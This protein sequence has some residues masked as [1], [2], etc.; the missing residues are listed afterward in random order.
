MNDTVFSYWEGPKSPLIEICQQSL[1]RWNR[2]VRI[3]GPDD[4][5]AEILEATAGISLAYR[6]DL[7]R[8]WA[9]LQ[10]GGIWVDADTV[11]VGTLTEL[12][13]IPQWD[14][15]G[16]Y[17]P[18]QQRGWAADGVLA[19]PIGGRQG[20]PVL[21]EMF[22]E[23]LRSVGRIQAGKKVPYGWTSV[24]LASEA[25][26]RHR[27][28]KRT[29]RKQHWQLHPVPWYRAR[30]IFFR[31]APA[32]RHEQSSHWN[33]NA[34]LYH[35]TNVVTKAW[36]HHSRDQ[37]LSGHTFLAFLTQKA[38]CCGGAIQGRSR[39][40]L[41]RLPDGHVRGAEV[42]VF[43]GINAR[44]LLQQKRNLELLLVDRWAEY[45][46]GRYRQTQD[47][48]S[49]FSQE[50]WE[51]I[52]NVVLPRHLEF[53]AGRYEIDRRWS[54]QAAADVPDRSLDFVFIDGDHSY[55][56]VRSDLIA[57]A[58]K[59]KPGGFL[60]GHDYNHPQEGTCYGVQKAVD[61]LAGTWNLPIETGEDYSWF[62]RATPSF[63]RQAAEGILSA[64][65]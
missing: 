27:H 26:Q 28:S 9:L 61:E 19:T 30:E 38:L 10:F 52:F 3:L 44:H 47:H 53:A 4:L 13:Q 11:C 42:G 25:W 12:E 35:L 58:R 63:V 60:G 43:R 23:C 18:H 32:H 31:S 5:P 45:P 36:K 16:V 55:E 46:P 7:V 15:L 62:I 22:D 21:G 48:Q 56:G 39:E 8:L 40:I 49:R 54:D 20:S 51:H 24:G 1:C 64:N 2:K 17:N 41:R 59:V 14:L 33:P 50:R 29:R 65:H 37:L 57:W 34:K 6:S